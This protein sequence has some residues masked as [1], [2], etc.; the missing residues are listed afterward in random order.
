MI[1][2]RSHGYSVSTIKQRLLEEHNT[3]ADRPRRHFEKKLDEEKLRFLDESLAAND[4]L[5]ARWLLVKLQ[6]TWPDVGAS[7]Y[8]KTGA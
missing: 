7:L 3:I 2:L 4:E 5:T 6:E 1:A 8:D